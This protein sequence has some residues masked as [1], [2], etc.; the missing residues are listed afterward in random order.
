MVNKQFP[1]SS[2]HTKFAL[3][4]IATAQTLEEINPLVLQ[5]IQK[6]IA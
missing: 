5:E 6:N 1:K 2:L 4:K 3:L